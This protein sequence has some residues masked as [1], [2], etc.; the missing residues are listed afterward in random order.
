MIQA[1]I[2]ETLSSARALAVPCRVSRCR[3]WLP[4]TFVSRPFPRSVQRPPA[5]A[6]AR[7]PSRP[8]WSRRP[9]RKRQ[10]GWDRPGWSA[11]RGLMR[12]SEVAKDA[13]DR[14]GVEHHRQYLPAPPT[15]TLQDVIEP[16][17]LDEFGPRHPLRPATR[18]HPHHETRTQ[19]TKRARGRHRPYEDRR[20]ARP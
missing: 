4:R 20:Q 16:D 9:L 12:E 19:A 15:R 8:G 18:S 11:W 2:L 14:L 1:L 13:L 6:P 10:H 5:I 3:W 7:S 17:P